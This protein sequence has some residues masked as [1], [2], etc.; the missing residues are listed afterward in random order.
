M[1]ARA[2]TSRRAKLGRASWWWIPI[3]TRTARCLLLTSGC[4][5]EGLV[6]PIGKTATVALNSV[7]HKF[8]RQLL[9]CQAFAQL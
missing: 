8:G 6:V 5:A 7:V 3:L 2:T 9:A 4:C 1:E